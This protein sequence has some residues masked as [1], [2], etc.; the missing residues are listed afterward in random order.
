MLLYNT[1]SSRERARL[2]DEAGQERI[3]LSFYKYLRLHDPL[4]FR[5]QLFLAWN[6]LD[7]LGRI[8]VAPEGINAQVSVPAGN[9]RALKDHLDS[10]PFLKG[11]RLNVAV[12]QYGKSFLKLKIKVRRK[13]V[14]DGIADEAFDAAR[15]G[16]HVQAGDFHQLLSDP[17]AILVDVRN[18]Y[19]SEIGHFEGAVRPDAATFRESLDVLAAGLQEHKEGKKLVMYCTGG[20][21]C[22]KASA[23]FLH[24]GFRN[25]FQLEGGIIGYLRQVE[26]QG[27]ENKFLG[28]NFVFDGRMAERI[29]GHVVSSCHQCGAP[30]D[31]HRNCGNDAC[32]A[33]FIQCSACSKR[34]AGCCSGACREVAALPLDKQKALRKGIKTPSRD[35]EGV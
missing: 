26:A 31:T 20:I 35:G 15:V 28:K 14:A 10:I 22:E 6:P 4:G 8:Y 30:C 32:H 27:L 1:L 19:E 7:I 9:F 12:E 21:R 34:M 2:L 16:V 13:I 17:D 23:W 25:V 33:L 18:R 11:V 3:T 29:S 5:D 24:K